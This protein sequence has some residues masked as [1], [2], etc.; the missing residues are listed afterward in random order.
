M[1]LRKMK[2]EEA[3]KDIKMPKRKPIK[4]STPSQIVHNEQFHDAIRLQAYYNYLYRI[5]HNTHGD[6]LSDWLEAEK[7]I[8]DSRKRKKASAQ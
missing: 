4:K 7:H 3:V 5:T 6:Q 2:E 1:A 8:L